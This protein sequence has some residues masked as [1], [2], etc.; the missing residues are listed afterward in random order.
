MRLPQPTCILLF[1]GMIISPLARAQATLAPFPNDTRY[2]AVGDSITH[3]GW[4]S[5]YIDAFYQTR[6]PK[7]NLEVFDCGISGDTADGGIRRFDWDIAAHKPTVASIMFGMN[8]VGRDLYSASR[9]GPDVEKLR[10]TNIENWNRNI[11]NLVDLFKK[12]GIQVI[13]VTPSIFDDTSTMSSENFPGCNTG[14]GK[15][16]DLGIALAKEENLGLVDF[17]HPMA[18]LNQKLQ[19][20]NPASTIVGPDR[21]HPG[22]AGHL[23][24]AYLFLTA[25]HVPTEIAHVSIDGM[26]GSLTDSANCKVDRIKADSNG[27]TFSYLADALP[28]PID[29]SAA[30]AIKWEPAINDLNHETLTVTNLAKG[31]YDLTVDGKKIRSYTAEELGKGVNLAAEPTMPEYQQALKVLDLVKAKWGSIWVLRAIALGDSWAHDLPHPVTLEQMQPVLDAKIKE[32]AN[33]PW[34]KAVA[35]DVAKYREVKGTEEKIKGDV[36]WMIPQIQHAAQPVVHAFQITPAA[37]PAN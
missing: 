31:S 35:N 22:N 23:Y 14:L 32:T 5:I 21:V 12:N 6:F 26:S 11:R 29:P 9:T 28:F 18:A 33:G 8:D 3:I 2:A 27:L 17:Y 36:E 7:N 25:Q 34:A 1:L 4:Y 16:A 37:T 30:D 19:A 24:M 20:G 13:L 10:A 15:I